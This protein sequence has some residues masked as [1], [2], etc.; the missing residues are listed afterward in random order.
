VT[1]SGVTVLDEA[2][3]RR[4]LARM[5][6]GLEESELGQAHADELLRAAAAD[7]ERG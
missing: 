1:R 3:R 7:R 2:E 4:E 5:L 6:A